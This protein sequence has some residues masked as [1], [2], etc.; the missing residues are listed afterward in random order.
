[1]S[2][3]EDVHLLQQ[4]IYQSNQQKSENELQ[5]LN[6]MINRVREV[7][8]VSYHGTYSVNRSV[9]LDVCHNVLLFPFCLTD[10]AV[11]AGSCEEL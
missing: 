7:R 6:N 5:I 8:N 1:M 9:C 3:H 2:I 10:L 4:I 11:V